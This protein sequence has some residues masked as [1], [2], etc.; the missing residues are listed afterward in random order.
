MALRLLFYSLK[1]NLDPAV[2]GRGVVAQQ[3]RRLIDVHDQDIH[4]AVVIEVAKG[5][6]AAAVAG[7]DTGTGLRA[8]SAKVPSPR[9]R[10]RT[11]GVRSAYLG[12]MR[13]S[14]G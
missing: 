9:L 5:K 8:H 2:A 3:R 11:R 1:S 6:A 7:N 14:S 4:I 10:K 13:S 12:E